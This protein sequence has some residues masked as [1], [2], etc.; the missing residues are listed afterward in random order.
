MHSGVSFELE[1]IFLLRMAF[2]DALSRLPSGARTPA[3]KS[4]IA[5]RILRSAAEGKRDL[6][7]LRRAALI[8]LKVAELQ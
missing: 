1:T 5:L 3:I 6:V 8:D 7:D 4:E 2:D